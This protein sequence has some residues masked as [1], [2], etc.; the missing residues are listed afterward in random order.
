MQTHAANKCSVPFMILHLLT[1]LK[2]ELL[3]SSSEEQKEL[4]MI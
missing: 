3:F 1:L 4:I 2:E